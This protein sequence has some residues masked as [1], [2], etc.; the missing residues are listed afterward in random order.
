MAGVRVIA[1]DVFDSTIKGANRAH[2]ESDSFPPTGKGAREATDFLRDYGFEVTL[3][4]PR[5]VK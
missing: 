3:A 1:V 4:K 5:T 2:L